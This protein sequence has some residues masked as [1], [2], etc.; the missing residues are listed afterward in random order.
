V[1][2][3]Q[4]RPAA[5]PLGPL[6][7]GPVVFFFLKYLLTIELSLQFVKTIEK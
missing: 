6:G 4:I 2:A 7:F 3:F 1:L 5:D